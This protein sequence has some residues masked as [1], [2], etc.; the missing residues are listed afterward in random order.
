MTTPRPLPVW[1]SLMFVPVTVERF[2]GSAA[3]R[4][5]DAV[6]LDL[7]DAVPEADKARARDLVAAAAPVVGRGGADVLVRINRP[8]PQAVRDIEAALVPGIAGLLLPKA[9]SAEHVRMAAEVVDAVEAA[10]SIAPGTCRLVPMIETAGAYFRM[11]EIAAA[12]PRVV[13]MTLGTE[14]FALSAG[15]LPEAEG[16]LGPAQETVFAAAAAGILPLGFVGSIAGFA[17]GEAFRRVIRQSRRLGFQGALCIHPAQVAIANEEHSPDPE[18]VARAARMVAAYDA[19]LAAG[20]GAVTFEG[21]M[22]DV[23][24]VERARR[25]IARDAAIRRRAGAAG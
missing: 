12:H 23:P 14:D 16:L 1:R 2:V 18:A 15:M 19:A 7:E 22:I 20:Q 3:R 17:D 24:V 10:R 13:A 21:A 6:I 8:W 9:E 5:A 4:G 25:L 11:R